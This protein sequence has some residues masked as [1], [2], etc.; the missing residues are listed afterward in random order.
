[1]D[2]ICTTSQKPTDSMIQSA[3]THSKYFKGEYIP[4]KRLGSLSERECVLVVTKSSLNV[5]IK[6]QK[7]AFHP[8]M[9][10]LRVKRIKNGELDIFNKILGDITS[11]AVLDCTLGLAS[12]SLVLSK[13][14][15]CKGQVTS[16]E[17]SKLIYKI[18]KDGLGKLDSSYP[19]LSGLSKNITLKN[20]DFNNYIEGLNYGDFDLIYF[21]PMF[22]KPIENSPAIS[23][24]RDL[25]HYSPLSIKS[26]EKAKKLAKKAVIVKNNKNFPFEE[27]GLKKFT[28]PS[29]SVS[30]GI[31]LNK[32]E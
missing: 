13:L 3:I 28:L 2:I 24:L 31:Y 17:K 12:D 22:D 11:W 1:M 20:V 4:R 8:S 7:L 21:D 5:Y 19:E 26:L 23:P 10:M 30:Y 32:E 29:S 6:G 9:A 18:V 16:L 14:V 15:S 25:A 27:I